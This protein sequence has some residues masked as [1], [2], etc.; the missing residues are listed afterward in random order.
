[1]NQLIDFRKLEFSK[2]QVK[3]SENDLVQ[4][5]NEIIEIFQQIKP[6]REGSIAG[7]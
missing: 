5:S 7:W 3:A 6:G 4:F 1:M 2:M